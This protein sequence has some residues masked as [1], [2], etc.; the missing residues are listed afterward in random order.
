M[1]FTAA[2]NFT[3]LTELMRFYGD[4]DEIVFK[5][6]CALDEQE[7]AGLCRSARRLVHQLRLHHGSKRADEIAQSYG[8]AVLSVAL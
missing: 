6:H 7:I 5:S 8:I 1:K 3:S 2:Q 4:A